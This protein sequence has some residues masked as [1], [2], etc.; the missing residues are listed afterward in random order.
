MSTTSAP[1]GEG[2]PGLSPAGQ[3]RTV[4]DPDLAPFTADQFEY[5][6]V[7]ERLAERIRRG[8][9][10]RSGRFP[11]AA[12]IAR[13]YGVGAGVVKHARQ[14]LQQRGLIYFVPGHGTFTA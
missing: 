9:F 6:V 10:S 11:S 12:E 13:H 7:A 8:E 5:A 4:T 3:G 14:V 2:C 1:A